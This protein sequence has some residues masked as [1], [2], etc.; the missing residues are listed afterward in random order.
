M[1]C[2]CFINKQPFDVHLVLRNTD[3]PAEFKSSPYYKGQSRAFQWDILLF[4]QR[5]K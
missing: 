5:F 3:I 1:H 4:Q 2:V